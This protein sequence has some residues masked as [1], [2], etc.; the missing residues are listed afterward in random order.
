MVTI[1]IM[2]PGSI[3]REIITTEMC[4]DC[5]NRGIAQRVKHT[6]KAYIVQCY[7]CREQ[8]GMR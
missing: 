4:P 3:R 2:Q 7:R 6:G 8:T 1:R 5:R